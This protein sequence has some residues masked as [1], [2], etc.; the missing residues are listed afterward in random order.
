MTKV[1]IHHFLSK[2]LFILANLSILA[3]LASQLFGRFVWQLELFSHFVPYYAVILVL[4]GLIYPNTQNNRKNLLPIKAMPFIRAMFL[5]IGVGLIIY[6][7]PNYQMIERWYN[8]P[9]DTT[10]NSSPNKANT[11]KK[12][13]S[14][15]A[16][17]NVNISNNNKAKTLAQLSNYNP[18]NLILL[19]AGGD[20]LPH[21]Q[22]LKNKY[23]THCGD[24]QHS[25]FAMQ[26]FSQVATANCEMIRLANLTAE[27]PLIKLTLNKEQIIYAIHPP[28]PINDLLA[29]NRLAYLQGVHRLIV[30]EK[31]S[32]PKADVMV[33][34]DMNST[35]FSP[36]YRDFIR[37]TNLQRTTAGG[38]VT[39]Q[40]LKQPL[41]I[42]LGIGIDH[43]L[44][45]MAW[46]DKVE[47][48]D[49]QG[50]DHRGILIY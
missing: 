21:L 3:L 8:I 34:G 16:Y 27:L 7:L 6:C 43:Y 2:R 46:H 35:A 36:V 45:T 28:P 40:P 18:E 25:P 9:N 13:S 22:I 32:H 15:I 47:I 12:I 39:W 44:T 24:D 33:I 4:A 17:Q 26:V 11:T 23:P 49:L 5:V 48:L 42:G 10:D 14:F 37:D 29:E 31:Q 1:Q 20:W 30:Q 50:S 38:T 41:K 19:E